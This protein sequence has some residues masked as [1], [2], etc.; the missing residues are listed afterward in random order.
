MVL[1]GALRG[2]AMGIQYLCGM[3][4]GTLAETNVDSEAQTWKLAQTCSNSSCNLPETDGIPLNTSGVYEFSVEL[5]LNAIYC[6]Q[7]LPTWI[8]DGAGRKSQR[9]A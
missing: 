6:G 3:Q 1:R 7:T 4:V 2:C 9:G 8:Q 5:G